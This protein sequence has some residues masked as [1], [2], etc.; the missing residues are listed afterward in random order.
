M[1]KLLFGILF[2]SF[3]FPVNSETQEKIQRIIEIKT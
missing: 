3:L 1:K 2:L